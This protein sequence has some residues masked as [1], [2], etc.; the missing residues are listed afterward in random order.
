MPLPLISTNPSGKGRY[1]CF[2]DELLDETH[3]GTVLESCGEM[4]LIR[5]EET[6]AEVMRLSRELEG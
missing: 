1:V 5:D 2:R 4:H 3:D 6:G